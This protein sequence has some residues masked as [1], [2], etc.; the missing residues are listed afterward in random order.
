MKDGEKADLGAEVL[1]IE[2]DRTKG[3]GC[4]V[5][6]DVVDLNFVLIGDDGDLVRDRTTWKYSVSSSSAW[7]SSIHWARAND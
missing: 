3:L 6:Q 5:E 7:R 4:R 1:R 2:R